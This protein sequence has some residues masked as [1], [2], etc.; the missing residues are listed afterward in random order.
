MDCGSVAIKQPGCPNRVEGDAPTKIDFKKNPKK[1]SLLILGS[2]IWAWTITPA[3]R[4]YLLKNKITKFAFFCTCG[5]DN[6]D[7]AEKIQAISSK[8]T[9]MLIIKDK[10]LDSKETEVKINNFI[11][12]V[13]R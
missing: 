9:A 10:E 1:Y 6:K 3:L 8:P 4:E 2:P 7:L 5:G 12:A 13:R 11:R